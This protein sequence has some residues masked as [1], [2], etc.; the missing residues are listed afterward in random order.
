LPFWID[1]I[2]VKL[3]DRRLYQELGFVGKTPRGAV[4]WKF[5]AEQ[6][7]TVVEDIVYKW[8]ERER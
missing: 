7:T 4:A 1:G 6:V 8:D 2:V 3:D 5:A